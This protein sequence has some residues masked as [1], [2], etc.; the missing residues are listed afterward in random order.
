MADGV[1]CRGFTASGRVQGVGFR[2]SAVDAASAVGVTGWV[3]NRADGAVEGVAFGLPE[4]L[5][6]FQQFLQRGPQFAQV[7]QVETH[8][9]ALT[10]GPLGPVPVPQVFEIRR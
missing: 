1:I 10:A 4:Q 5:A 6:Q 3:R 9:V 2:A 7:E 8:D